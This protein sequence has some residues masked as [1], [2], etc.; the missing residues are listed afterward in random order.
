MT[1]ITGSIFLSALG[2]LLVF[3]GILPFL[4]PE[5]WRKIMKQMM[6]QSDRTLRIIGLVSMLIGLLLVSVVHDFL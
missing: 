6:M 5:G 2:L 1:D 3:E 4:S